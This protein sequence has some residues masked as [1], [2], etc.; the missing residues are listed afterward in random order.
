MIPSSEDYLYIIDSVQECFKITLR[1]LKENQKKL[2]EE[3]QDDKGEGEKR[4][5]RMCQKE[6]RSMVELNETV[7]ASQ[8]SCRK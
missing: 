2:L 4:A 6:K 3:K 5:S 1:D 7:V 8:G